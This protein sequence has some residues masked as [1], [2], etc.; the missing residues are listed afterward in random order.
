MFLGIK[1]ILNP[2]E[3]HKMDE[4]FL[5][6]NTTRE[7]RERI[8]LESLGLCDG[9]AGCAGCDGLGFGDPLDYYKPYI[10]GQKELSEIN[11]E[12]KNGGSVK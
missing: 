10:D 3:G 2:K 1:D 7:E 8:V 9:C 5:I 6:K 4:K 11:A 12:Y